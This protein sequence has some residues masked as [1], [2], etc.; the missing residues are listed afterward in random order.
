MG[1]KLDLL[2]SGIGADAA[3]LRGVLCN[4]HSLF[5]THKARVCPGGHSRGQVGA[6]TQRR[7]VQVSGRVA[8][9]K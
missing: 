4:G 5:I 6:S 2:D 3:Q 7:E 9:S 8:R 1:G